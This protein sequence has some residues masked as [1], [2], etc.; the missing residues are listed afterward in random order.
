MNFKQV[1]YFSFLTICLSSC[2]ATK[3]KNYTFNQK[4]SAEQVKQDIAVLKEVLEANHPSLYW[5]TSKDSIDIFF[6]AVSAGITDSLTEIQA[7]NKI[8]YILSKIRCGHTSVH[9]SKQFIALADK[10]KYPQFPLSIKVWKDS[11]VVLGYYNKEDSLLKRGT[12]ITSINGKKNKEIIDSIFSL[13]STDGNAINFKNQSLSSNF[14]AWYKNAF[15]VDSSYLITY[16]D[17][18]KQEK[19]ITIQWHNPKPDTTKKKPDTTKTTL[20]TPVKPKPTISKKQALLQSYRY[21]TFDSATSTA[22]IKI[23][24]FSNGHLRS[25]IKNCFSEIEEKE[26]KNLIIDLRENGGG[27]IDLSVLFLKYL[28]SSDFKIGDTIAATNR[29]LSHK[30]YIKSWLSYWL[31]GNLFTSKKADGW[32]H[33]G[34]YEKHFFSPKT[35]HHFNGNIY[36]IQGGYTFSA[37]TIFSSF[38]KGQSNVTIIGEESGGGFYGN[39]AMQIPNIYLPH[40]KLRVRLPLYRYVM[41]KNRN[42]GQ[43]VLPDI[44]IQPN[45]E[46]IKNGIDPKISAIKKIIAEANKTN[47]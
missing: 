18:N 34:W 4:Y 35:N 24:T 31:V 22:Y 12:V 8:A 32:V 36:I 33:N 47:K 40:T 17:N 29:S 16:L 23:N 11:F 2:V 9:Y 25:F 14:P 46:A 1:F 10:Y 43:G 28:K 42:K 7:K 15:G 39:T 20:V 19:N 5:F 41:D 6:N 38:L 37:A 26:I 13:M 27:K 3:N 45:S 21:I 44:D 30:K